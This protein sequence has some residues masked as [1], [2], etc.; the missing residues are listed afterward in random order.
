MISKLSWNQSCQIER[1][2]RFLILDYLPLLLSIIT[3]HE[4]HQ[5][6]HNLVYSNTEPV[7]HHRVAKFLNRVL[8]CLTTF[9]HLDLLCG[10][11]QHSKVT[12]N[13]PSAIRING[14]FVGDKIVTLGC[15]TADI[16]LKQN[17]HSALND[18]LES[19]FLRSVRVYIV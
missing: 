12:A 17:S 2:Y 7:S 13:F 18:G 10:L 1:K 9:G 16:A 8:A 19:K 3:F 4:K 11:Y 14:S 6:N 15:L 5:L